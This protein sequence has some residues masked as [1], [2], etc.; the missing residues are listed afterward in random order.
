[1]VVV[2]KWVMGQEAAK[3]VVLVDMG[4]GIVVQ[5]TGG[6]LHSIRQRFFAATIQALGG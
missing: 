5:G 1:M 6:R 2:V 3:A 4:L